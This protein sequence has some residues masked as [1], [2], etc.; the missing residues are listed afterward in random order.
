MLKCAADN[1]Q[2]TVSAGC[3]SRKSDRVPTTSFSSSLKEDIDFDTWIDDLS[4]KK[5][6]P[7]LLNQR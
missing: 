1:P 3:S 2:N 5:D 4:F 6:I 7:E